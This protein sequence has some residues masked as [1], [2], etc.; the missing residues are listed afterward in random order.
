MLDHNLVFFGPFLIA[1]V[2]CNNSFTLDILSVLLLLSS[3]VFFFVFNIKG[4]LGKKWLTILFF[5]PAIFGFLPVFYRSHSMNPW[6]RHEY[7]SLFFCTLYHIKTTIT[8]SVNIIS[9]YSCV[10][11]PFRMTGE[12]L[13]KF[14]CPRVVPIR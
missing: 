5:I 7:W 11:H 12:H 3:M 8:W 14:I 10:I 2:I 4:F 1:P 6:M 9:M 13:G